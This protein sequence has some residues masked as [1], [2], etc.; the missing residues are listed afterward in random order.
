M[1]SASPMVDSASWPDSASPVGHSASPSVRKGQKL[2]FFDIYLM[3]TCL[4]HIR[5]TL[6]RFF[7]IYD[8]NLDLIKEIYQLIK[9]LISLCDN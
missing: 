4:Y 1:D 3:E 2:G 5:S 6:I 9:Y 8:Y 7:D